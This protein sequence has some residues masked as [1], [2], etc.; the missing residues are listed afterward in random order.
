[1]FTAEEARSLLRNLHKL[2]M[3]EQADALAILEELGLRR[4]QEAARAAL[5]PFAKLIA[6]VLQIETEPKV[7]MVGPHHRK[8]ATLLDAMARGEKR[9]ILISVA[10]RMGKSLLSSYLFPAWFMGK[11]PNRNIIMASHTADLATDFGRKVRDLIATPEYQAVFPDVKLLADSKAAG[12]WVTNRGGNYFAVGVGGAVAG[13]G[14]NCV[15]FSCKVLTKRGVMPIVQVRV[16]D[17]V[18]GHDHER[19]VD[20]WTQVLAIAASRKSEL[21]RF[22]AF[23]C[24]PEHRIYT[25]GAYKPA[26]EVCDANMRTVW[27]GVPAE[28][29]G[30]RSSATSVWHPRNCANLLLKS[31]FACAK[32]CAVHL[33]LRGAKS[34]RGE[35]VQEMLLEREDSTAQVWKLWEVLRSYRIRIR[36]KSTAAWGYGAQ[37]LQW[38]LLP[39][40][41]SEAPETSSVGG[42]RVPYLRRNAGQREKILQHEMLFGAKSAQ[43][44]VCWSVEFQ[45]A[46]SASSRCWGLRVLWSGKSSG[47]GAPHRPRR[48]ESQHGQPSPLMRTLPRA[49]SSANVG[50]SAAD[51]APILSEEG[52]LVVD[53]QTGTHNFYCEGVLAHNCLII[54][55]PYSEQVIMSGNTDIYDQTWN[56]FQTG[57]LQRMAPDGIICIIHTRWHKSDLIGR[58]QNQMAKN[59]E[60]D[61]W[62]IVE[63]PAVLN[64]DTPEAKSLWP[65]RWSLEALLQK[66]A[67]MD[68]SYW[69]AQY[70]QNPTSEAGALIKREWWKIWTKED[71]PECEYTIMSIDSAQETSNKADFTA[72]QIWGVFMY[73]DPKG[74]GEPQ[75]NIIL[76][77][78]WKKRMEFP[79]LKK[80]IYDEYE[81]WQPDCCI[82]EKKSSGSALYQ[83]MRATGVPVTEFTPSKGN[84]K[85]ARVN[86][87]SDIFKSGLVWYPD[88][89]RWA[90]DIIEECAEFPNGDHDDQV[91]CMTLAL[92]R[93][94]TGGFIRLTSDASEEPYY[95]RTRRGGYY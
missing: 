51:I 94:R 5:L 49:L 39:G 4:K 60:A 53:I 84:D 43:R 30:A 36:Q 50:S 24:T 18:W 81:E 13:R 45:K 15:Y 89:R 85:I 88:C 42:Y 46:R 64:I 48:E 83:E 21:V 11:F 77:N 22:G 86:S 71:P 20:C 68:V 29:Q 47:S 34:A 35:N 54:D 12:K 73:I 25:Q 78:G 57:P 38:V 37:L 14:A 93:F 91:D 90:D 58:L 28:S 75:A 44:G 66:R 69:N 74:N 17:F 16:G 19:G 8:L 65:E 92:R 6:P 70:M 40:V 26:T 87:V 52:F 27:Q 76:I 82:I 9:R 23:S 2:P 32:S 33:R 63:F 3:H 55:D 10:P 79:E 1:M 31:L 67:N 61:Q 72:C 95:G 80:I 7:F 41:S 59:P 56:W 62:E